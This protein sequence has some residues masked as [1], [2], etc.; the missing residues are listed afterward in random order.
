MIDKMVADALKRIIQW[1][2]RS[3]GQHLRQMRKKA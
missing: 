1:V 2:N 3:A